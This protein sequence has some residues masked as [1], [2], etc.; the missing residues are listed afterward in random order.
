VEYLY[1]PSEEN[2][3]KGEAIYAAHYYIKN[4][5]EGINGKAGKENQEKKLVFEKVFRQSQ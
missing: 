4:Y 2:P 5:R 3:R 1:R